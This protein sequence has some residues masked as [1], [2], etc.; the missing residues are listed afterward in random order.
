MPFCSIAL[1]LPV[2]LLLLLLLLLLPL[3]RMLPLFVASSALASSH[4]AASKVAVLTS[5][6]FGGACSCSCRAASATP[7]TLELK[8]AAVSLL[9][10]TELTLALPE[11]LGSLG[12]GE[13]PGTAAEAAEA[14]EAA[15]CAV[16][17][18]AAGPE[19]EPEAE[20]EP[21]RL[22]RAAAR[23]LAAFWAGADAGMS[24][25]RGARP[26]RLGDLC[27]KETAQASPAS[28]SSA[29]SAAVSRRSAAS[30]VASSKDLVTSFAEA[31]ASRHA[32]AA[33][34]TRSRPRRLPPTLLEAATDTQ[35]RPLKA[36]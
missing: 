30:R 29:S 9:K 6:S 22:T 28:P 2:L 10:R 5:L 25:C 31:W 24:S 17:E 12:S 19:P 3:L 14:A 32:T 20:P 13:R 34:R 33:M 18:A 23:Y 36:S 1:M 16:S 15:A 35:P 11:A 7:A 27:S 8:A 21:A 4:G 26:F